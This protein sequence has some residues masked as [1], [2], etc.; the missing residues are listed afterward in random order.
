MQLSEEDIQVI[1][2]FWNEY[3]GKGNWKSHLKLSD[4]MLL[5]IVNSLKKYNIGGHMHGH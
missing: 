2:D 3:K 4:D 5:A 1:F